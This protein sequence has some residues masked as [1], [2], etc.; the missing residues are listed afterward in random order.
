MDANN[1]KTWIWVALGIGAVVLLG[2]CCV[3]SAGFLWTFGYVSTPM[4]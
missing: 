4:P 1:N 2:C 3:A